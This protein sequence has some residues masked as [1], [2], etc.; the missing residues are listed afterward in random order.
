M[1][2]QTKKNMRTAK[3][4]EDLEYRLT[5]LLSLIICAATTAFTFSI[6][7]MLINFI[8]GLLKIKVYVLALMSLGTII[9]TC[10]LGWGVGVLAD[11]CFKKLVDC[12][13]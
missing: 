1:D 2:I 3:K 7:T 5:I 12:G 13:D 10:L 6:G 4:I 8:C 11:F 9:L